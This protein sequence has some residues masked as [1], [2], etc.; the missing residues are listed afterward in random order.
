VTSP[1][2][3]ILTL[4][5]LTSG[6][7]SV[8]VVRSWT[9]A[10]EFSLVSADNYLTGTTFH[11]TPNK[12]T[13]QVTLQEVTLPEYYPQFQQNKGNKLSLHIVTDG[14]SFTDGNAFHTNVYIMKSQI[15]FIIFPKTIE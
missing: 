4:T 15:A 9:L 10:T 2:L 14:F 12:L 8:V 1:Q 5:S 3:Q 13:E 7:L 6:C 11:T